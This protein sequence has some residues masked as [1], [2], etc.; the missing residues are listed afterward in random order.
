MNTNPPA[1]PTSPK[2]KTT[3]IDDR[4]MKRLRQKYVRTLKRLTNYLPEI[5]DHDID[6]LIFCETIELRLKRLLLNS[7]PDIATYS[8]AI[9]SLN[10][11]AKM[12]NDIIQRLAI[13]RHD[14]LNNNDTGIDQ[15]HGMIYER[16]PYAD[17]VVEEAKK[18]LEKD[19]YHF[20]E[21]LLEEDPKHNQERRES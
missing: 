1:N 18:T 19:P 4:E 13:S 16:K 3:T 10:K 14:R 21:R 9:D 8:S 11:L 2:P 17:R 20:R 12:R 7:E 5:D 6:H 15:G